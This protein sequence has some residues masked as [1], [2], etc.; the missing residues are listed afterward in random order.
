MKQKSLHLHFTMEPPRSKKIF[1]VKKLMIYS[2]FLKKENKE[3]LA[4]VPPPERIADESTIPEKN[5]DETTAPG[6]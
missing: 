5:V 6:S 3:L 1:C 2:N 4:K